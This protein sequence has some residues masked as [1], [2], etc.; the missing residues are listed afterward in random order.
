MQTR[1]PTPEGYRD[2]YFNLVHLYV[3]HHACRGPIFGLQIIEE[4]A[5]IGYK[6][7]PGTMYPLLVALEKKGLLR[8][9][10]VKNHTARRIYRATA[11]GRKVYSNA[12]E[13]VE[14]LLHAISAK[15]I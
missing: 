5:R 12:K 1:G 10:E 15:K 2:L 9:R 13:H 14:K 6:V 8:S 3:L 7:S 4:L 11:A